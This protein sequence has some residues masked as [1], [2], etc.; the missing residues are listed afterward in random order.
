MIRHFL[1]LSDYS[2]EELRYILDRARELKAKK[3]AGDF[4][5]P[6]RGKTLTMVFEKPSTRTRVSF[7]AGFYQLGGNVI[8]MN[9]ADSQLG[10]NESIADTSRVISRMCD[11]IMM[12]TFG[13]SK[14]EEMAINSA[15]PVINGLTNEYHPCQ[16]MAD[17][18]TFEEHRGSIEG[19]TVADRKSVV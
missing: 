17:I 6:F 2:K 4:Y 7:E 1:K 3:A 16:I 18:M 9:T 14:L 13:Q 12:R 15:V 19:Q 10:R 11:C 8:H 5:E